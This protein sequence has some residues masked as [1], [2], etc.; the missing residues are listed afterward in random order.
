MLTV[1]ELPI[2][3]H[4]IEFRK[5]CF[6]RA[7]R[8]QTVDQLDDYVLDPVKLEPGGG[9]AVGDVEPAGHAGAR[10]T[11]CSAAWRR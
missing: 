11:A 6:V 2:G 7:E 4:R 3:A 1:T 5:D 10:S 8:R 9:R